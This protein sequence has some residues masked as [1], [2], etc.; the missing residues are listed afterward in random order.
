MHGFTIEVSQDD[1]M[2]DITRPDWANSS[3]LLRDYYDNEWG[4][5]VSDTPVST[6]ASCS[7][8]NRALRNSP[9]ET[10]SLREAFDGFD[11]AKIA[12]YTDDDVARLLDN[13][14][15]I[16]NEKKLSSDHE[17]RGYRRARECGRQ[18]CRTRLVFCAGRSHRAG[19]DAG[20]S[21]ESIALA[22]ELKRH[23]FTSLDR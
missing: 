14:E 10:S 17:C 5:V 18:P 15:I 11:P 23:G 21:A 13:P 3:D 12:M 2:C 22:Y 20:R 4:A 9:Q 6:S 16:R 1:D 19:P 8:S 7:A